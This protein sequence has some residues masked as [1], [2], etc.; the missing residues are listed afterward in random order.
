MS[1]G[2]NII[3]IMPISSRP[4]VVRLWVMDRDGIELCVLAEVAREMPAVGE[5][6]WWQSGRIYFDQ[7]RQTLKKIGFSFR[8]PKVELG[9]G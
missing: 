4:G 5:P 2:G 6:V 3:E 9:A 1:V 8:P 7:D